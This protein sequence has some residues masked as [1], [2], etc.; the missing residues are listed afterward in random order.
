MV[1]GSDYVDG[2]QIDWRGL[3]VAIFGGIVIGF[4][5]GITRFVLAVR[6]YVETG[7]RGISGFLSDLVTL[8]YGAP[9]SLI[10]GAW[11]GAR[12]IVVGSGPLGFLISLVLVLTTLYLVVAGVRRLV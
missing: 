6:D 9:E 5:E 7:Y 8:V 2:T 4:T 10:S 1:S 12:E 3:S 11:S